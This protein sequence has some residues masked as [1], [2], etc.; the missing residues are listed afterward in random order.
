MSQEIDAAS[1]VARRADVVWR[2]DEGFLVV[3]TVDGEVI[4]AAGSAGWVWDA[5]PTPATPEE[6][7]VRIATAHGLDAVDILPDVVRFLRE[8]HELGF[9]E[10]VGAPGRADR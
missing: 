9:V 2:A 3:A 6:L 4:K 1:T 7:S 5:L 8:L 10:A